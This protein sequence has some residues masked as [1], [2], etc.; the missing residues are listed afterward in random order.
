MQNAARICTIRDESY[1]EHVSKLQKGRSEPGGAG[2]EPESF[3]PHE[4]AWQEQHDEKI[5]ALQ[6]L[7]RV[8]LE[9]ATEG[10]APSMSLLRHRI[11][12]MEEL[13]DQARTAVEKLSEAV[14]KLRAPALR[15]G[16]LLQKLANGRALVCVNGTDY[17]CSVDPALPE[18]ALETGT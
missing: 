8:K 15:L 1:N 9:L 6:I 11:V 13:Q 18:V 2:R 5:S 3:P 12:E 17:V 14:E 7:D 4:P 10:S 16:T